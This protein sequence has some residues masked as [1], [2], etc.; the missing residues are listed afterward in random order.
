MK[1]LT[2]KKNVINTI[3]VGLALAASAISAPAQ[4]STW[5]NAYGVVMSN[6]CVAP[7]GAYMSFATQSGP[8]GTGCT[9]YFN[10]VPGLY[11]GTFR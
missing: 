4:A 6:T 7:N 1:R 3:A 2:I 5:I 10:G 9:F 11:Y 8:I